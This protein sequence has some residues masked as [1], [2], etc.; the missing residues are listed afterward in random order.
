MWAPCHCCCCC[1]C[2][3]LGTLN[4]WISNVCYAVFGV[5]ASFWVCNSAMSMWEPCHCCCCS[6]SRLSSLNLQTMCRS[7][8]C[9][10]QASVLSN[11]CA[12][13][14]NANQPSFGVQCANQPGELSIFGMHLIFWVCSSAMSMWAPC[15]CCCCCSCSHLSIL[16]LRIS[17]VWKAL[18]AILVRAVTQQHELNMKNT[19]YTC[20]N[21]HDTQHKLHMQMIKD[22]LTLDPHLH[23][24]DRWYPEALLERSW[25]EHLNNYTKYTLTCKW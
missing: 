24:D 16:N 2:S 10:N 1:S 14:P 6:C 25:Y 7:T 15:H 17:Y 3:R 8:N 20:K 23:A 4:L 11:Q 5:H 18:I 22:A 21:I 19:N 9:A 13:Q 12:N